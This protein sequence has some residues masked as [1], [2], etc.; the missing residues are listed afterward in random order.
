MLLTVAPPNLIKFPE[1]LSEKMLVAPAAVGA[2][3]FNGEVQVNSVRSSTPSLSSSTSN[4]SF[5]E[6]LSESTQAA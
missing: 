1:L 6:S 3:A 2:T 4:T 5:I